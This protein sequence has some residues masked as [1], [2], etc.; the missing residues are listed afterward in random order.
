MPISVG[1]DCVLTRGLTKLSF[2]TCWPKASSLCRRPRDF[3]QLIQCA[4]VCTSNMG[5]FVINQRCCEISMLRPRLIV[6]KYYKHCSIIC[7][8]RHNIS[9]RFQRANGQSSL[10]VS[11]RPV[12][13]LTWSLIHRLDH[14]LLKLYP[15]AKYVCCPAAYVRIWL[16]W[17]LVPTSQ[18]VDEKQ[19]IIHW[20]LQYWT[21]SI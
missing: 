2:R 15:S 4:C 18:P 19:N 17:H 14:L 9:L 3:H 20:R 13:A 11:Y 1:F 5:N 8:G 10:C 6:W 7:I 21:P 12:S 16:S